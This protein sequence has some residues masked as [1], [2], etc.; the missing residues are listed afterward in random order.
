MKNVIIIGAG[1]HAQMCLEIVR[2]S[3]LIHVVAILDNDESLHQT[4]I[5]G[6]PVAGSDDMLPS[7]IS[8]KKVS[9]FGVGIGSVNSEGNRVREKLFERCVEVGLFP[10][11]VK[12]ADS[13]VMKTVNVGEGYQIF[14]GAVVNSRAKLGKG[15][16]IN[17]GAI[18]EHGCSLGDF[19]HVG[20][21][22][23]V[24]G[25]VTVGSGAFIG[26][27]ATI[28]QGLKLGRDATVAMGSV[29]VKD[30]EDSETV[31]GV[32]ARKMASGCK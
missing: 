32:P 2:Q 10:L 31:G 19:V 20:P 7:L 22:S 18:I 23:V 21:G 9:H 28:R 30:V 14:P 11:V 12:A 6:V 25:D 13:M 26:A 5:D 24:C 8:E 4:S 1:G 16:I 29:V 3:E 17:S 15:V 27:G